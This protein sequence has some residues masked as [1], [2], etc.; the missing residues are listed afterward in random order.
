LHRGA[1]GDRARPPPAERR[2]RRC[3]ERQG[4]P[5]VAEQAE[6]ERDHRRPHDEGPALTG[7]GQRLSLHRYILG[8]LIQDI[9]ERSR[10][11]TSSIWWSASR[12]RMARKPAR[13]AWF[14]S[15]HS[16]ANCPDWISPRI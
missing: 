3:P 11:P 7:D 16:R 5:A 15:T 9:I 10:L 8:G 6:A 2:H 12:R 1:G 4:Q 14:S 13:L